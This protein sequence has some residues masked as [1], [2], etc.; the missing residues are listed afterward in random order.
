MQSHVSQRFVVG[1]GPQ[2][3]LLLN[4]LLRR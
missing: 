3:L 2:G 1:A 4:L